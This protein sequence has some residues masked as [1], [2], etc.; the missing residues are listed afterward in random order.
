MDIVI[1]LGYFNMHE[2]LG[3]S[4]ALESANMA[5][6]KL[7]ANWYSSYHPY[8]DHGI[9]LLALQA[10]FLLNSEMVSAELQ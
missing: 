2:D 6:V 7:Q 1:S 9:W 5:K 10:R 4:I 3:A 8:V